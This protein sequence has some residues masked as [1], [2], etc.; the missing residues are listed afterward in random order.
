M[1]KLQ[2]KSQRFALIT[3]STWQMEDHPSL[4]T[5]GL[6]ISLLPVGQATLPSPTLGYMDCFQDCDP[7]KGKQPPCYL[8]TMW[9]RSAWCFFSFL[10]ERMLTIL[11]NASGYPLLWDGGLNLTENTFLLSRVPLNEYSRNSDS[12]GAF[13][14]AFEEGEFTNQYKWQFLN[15]Q[16]RRCFAAW[17]FTA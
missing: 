17:F 7:E 4:L 2:V 10:V 14:Y 6:A 15:W 16:V 5:S 11:R 3:P 12:S 8:K 1:R 9:A 13:W